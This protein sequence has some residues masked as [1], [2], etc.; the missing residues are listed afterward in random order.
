MAINYK[1]EIPKMV[2]KKQDGNFVNVVTIVFWI[3]VATTTN[4]GEIYEESM[5]GSMACKS[6]SETDFTAYPNLTFEQVCGWLEAELG[7]DSFDE[8]LAER[9]EEKINPP[10]IILPNPWE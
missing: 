3:R 1:W 8:E 10:T 6:P 7:V 5:S 2:T 4:D 9:I